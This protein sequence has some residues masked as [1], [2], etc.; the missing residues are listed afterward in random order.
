MTSL[1]INI[2]WESVGLFARNISNTT[3]FDETCQ[4]IGN[5][6]ID[7]IGLEYCMVFSQEQ[8]DGVY[9][10]RSLITR[11]KYSN[12]IID[13][14]VYLKSTDAFERIKKMFAKSSDMIDQDSLNQ[15]Q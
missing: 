7:S 3:T 10:R 15:N 11:S 2:N 5:F 1:G 8:K 14:P 6:I 13:F 9:I 4:V 12:G